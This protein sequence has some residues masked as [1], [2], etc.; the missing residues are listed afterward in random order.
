[1]H[2]SNLLTPSLLQVGLPCQ[3]CPAGIRAGPYKAAQPATTGGP[4]P[5]PRAAAQQSSP[6]I[7][8]LAATG[9]P[10]SPPA[11]PPLIPHR[12]LAS[13]KGKKQNTPQHPQGRASTLARAGPADQPHAVG[14]GRGRSS[15]GPFRRGSYLLL[16][17]KVMFWEVCESF[18]GLT[19]ETL[20]WGMV[21]TRSCTQHEGV[22]LSSASSCSVF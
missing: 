19:V 6:S 8:S 3:P 5:S 7:A 20:N 1:V 14:L 17:V 11:S 2:L 9:L 15:V 21:L 22:T 18:T 10:T 4:L 16:G 12:S 13:L